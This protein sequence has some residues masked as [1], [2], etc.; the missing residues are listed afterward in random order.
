MKPIIA[1]DLAENGFEIAVSVHPGKVAEHHRR[2][3]AEQS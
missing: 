2:S 3:R 1:V